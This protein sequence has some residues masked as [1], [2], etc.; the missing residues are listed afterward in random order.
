M[1][2]TQLSALVGTGLT[3]GGRHGERF[4]FSLLAVVGN[5][6]SLQPDDADARGFAAS[7]RPGNRVQAS[8]IVPNG[9]YLSDLEVE[10]WSPSGRILSVRARTPLQFAQRR[11]SFRVPTEVR[12]ELAAAR[13]DDLMTTSGKTLDMSTEGFSVVV[14]APLRAGERASAV[15]RLADG[16][17]MSVVRVIMPGTSARLPTRVHIDQIG[18]G[19]LARLTTFL[20]REEIRRVRTV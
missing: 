5:V 10:S 18:S 4:G 17:A 6:G 19:D 12:V 13:G 2:E 1:T 3:V 16:P 8:Y 15:L 14:K 7:L 9:V 11:A 20:R